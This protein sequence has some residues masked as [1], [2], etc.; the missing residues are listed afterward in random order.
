MDECFN[1]RLSYREESVAMM[2]ELTQSS[3]EVADPAP[4]RGPDWKPRV[5]LTAGLATLIDGLR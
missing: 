1:D 4:P 2:H 5:E 3:D